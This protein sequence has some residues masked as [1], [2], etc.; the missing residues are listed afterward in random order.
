MDLISLDTS[1]TC[2]YDMTTGND[3]VM[4]VD[5]STNMRA[6]TSSAWLSGWQFRV[7]LACLVNVMKSL[8]W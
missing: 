3:N 8:G 6:T 7:Y 1:P 4:S 2:A 5:I